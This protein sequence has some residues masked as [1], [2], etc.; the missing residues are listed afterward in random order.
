MNLHTLENSVL[1]CVLHPKGAAV[2]RLLYKPKE[3]DVVVGL[4]DNNDRKAS[5]HYLGTLVGPVANRINNGRFTLNSREYQLDQNEG[6]QTLHGGSC[7]FSEVLWRLKDCSATSASFC[8]AMPDGWMGFTGSIACEVRYSLN[9][10]ALVVEILATSENRVA[11]NIAPHIYWNL[12]GSGDISQHELQVHADEYLELDQNNVPNGNILNTRDTSLDFQQ[13]TPIADRIFDHHLCLNGTGFRQILNLS[14]PNGIT[15]NLHSN[16]TGVQIYDGRHFSSTG[17]IGLN[18]QPLCDRGGI[19]LEPQGYPD[20]PN[21]DH[22]PS[23]F[24]DPSETYYHRSEFC[25]NH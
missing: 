2:A 4:Q 10:S 18:D 21:H 23:V 24:L 9:E 1:K 13:K 14:A 17:L 3:T 8:Y 6:M 11:V 16:Q 12:M 22:F 5:G 19:A 7:G 15:M 20:A 25:F